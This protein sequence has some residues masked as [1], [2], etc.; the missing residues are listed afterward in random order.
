MSPEFTA[1]AAASAMVGASD[2]ASCGGG[3]LS[4]AADCGAMAIEAPVGEAPV[5]EAK[6]ADEV[7]SGEATVMLAGRRD[8]LAA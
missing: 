8:V 1:G 6:A 3:S 5:G 2:C 4:L 7:L